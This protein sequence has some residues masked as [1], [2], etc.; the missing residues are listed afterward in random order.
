MTALFPK[1]GIDTANID[2][3]RCTS[4]TDRALGEARQ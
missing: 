1:P 2:W 3:K 4:A